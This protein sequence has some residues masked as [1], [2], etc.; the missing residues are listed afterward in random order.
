MWRFLAC[1]TFSIGYYGV[2]GLDLSTNSLLFSV[3]FASNFKDLKVLCFVSVQLFF[4]IFVSFTR[5]DNKKNNKVFWFN[6]FSSWMFF[7][8]L[9]M[10]G[11]ESSR[12]LLGFS[13]FIY[14]QIISPFL[15]SPFLWTFYF[16]ACLFPICY[17][18]TFLLF[19]LFYFY[20]LPFNYIFFLPFHF[21]FIN[22]WLFPFLGEGNST[23]L[24]IWNEIF[25]NLP[26]VSILKS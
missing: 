2:L 19:E 5:K 11:K 21:S 18:F 26:K 17:F 13:K 10:L 4:S 12:K 9:W 8:F 3:F 15:F 24:K 7:F 16:I 6:C 23:I 1:N 25:P 22:S 20:Y 14:F